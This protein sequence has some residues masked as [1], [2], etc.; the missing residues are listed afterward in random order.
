MQ[1]TITASLVACY[2]FFRCRIEKKSPWAGLFR[3]P[4]PHTLT[5]TSAFPNSSLLIQTRHTPAHTCIW[6]TDAVCFLRCCLPFMP[7]VI[8]VWRWCQS[9]LFLFI[10]FCTSHVY[11]RQGWKPCKRMQHTLN[12]TNS[13]GVEWSCVHKVSVWRHGSA[14]QPPCPS[15]RVQNGPHLKL[16]RIMR[17]RLEE[18]R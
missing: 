8:S 14:P 15:T 10:F 1:I 5:H 9:V 6:R 2:L 12:Y 3:I 16:R 13:D 18:R 17:G 4:R 7:D 11:E